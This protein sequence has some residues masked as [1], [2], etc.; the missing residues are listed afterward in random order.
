MAGYGS[1]VQMMGQS[2]SVQPQA[3][4]GMDMQMLQMLLAQVSPGGTPAAF[5]PPQA[6]A[7][8]G[9]GLPASAFVGVHL[10]GLGGEED[11]RL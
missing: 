1:P 7:T 10:Q 5:A 4:S 8:A 6:T 3:P 11:T 2:G 9:G